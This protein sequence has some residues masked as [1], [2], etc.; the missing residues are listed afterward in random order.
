M[1]VAEPLRRPLAACTTTWSNPQVKPCEKTRCF[2]KSRRAAANQHT[3]PSPCRGMLATSPQPWSIEPPCSGANKRAN[4]SARFFSKAAIPVAVR[5][6]LC[7]IGAPIAVHILKTRGCLPR[8]CGHGRQRDFGPL[9][10]LV[11]SGRSRGA[12]VN[13][14]GLGSRPAPG[15]PSMTLA[16][17]TVKAA[18]GRS[19]PPLDQPACPM[20]AAAQLWGA[21]AAACNLSIGVQV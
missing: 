1:T 3:H 20:L 17:I 21:L 4:P 5:G 18:G 7:P 16:K 12:R 9:S 8:A 11:Q 2:Y 10:R 6:D 15:G 14:H 13:S 19:T